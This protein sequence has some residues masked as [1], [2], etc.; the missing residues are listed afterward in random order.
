[1]SLLKYKNTLIVLGHVSAIEKHTWDQS[2][3]ERHRVCV[4]SGHKIMLVFNFMEEQDRD[5]AFNY[6]T[7][8]LMKY[9]RHGSL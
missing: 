9:Y 7:D 1:M 3:K 6:L 2:Y 8:Q 4:Y 5:E